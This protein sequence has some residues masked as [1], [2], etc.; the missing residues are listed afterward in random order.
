MVAKLG[1]F[2]SY[3]LPNNAQELCGNQPVFKTAQIDKYNTQ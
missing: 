1:K 3:T 2:R